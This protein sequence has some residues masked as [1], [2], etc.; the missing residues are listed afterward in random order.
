M[1][2]ILAIQEMKDPE[3]HVIFKAVSASLDV[4][5]PDKKGKDKYR[6]IS[7]MTTTKEIPGF[8]R[9]VEGLVTSMLAADKNAGN[10]GGEMTAPIQIPNRATTRKKK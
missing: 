8:D 9:I 10:E 5:L 1:R 3:T 4:T 7:A 2:L 6:R